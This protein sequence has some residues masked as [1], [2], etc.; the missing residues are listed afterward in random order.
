MITSSTLGRAAAPLSS[1]LQP[2]AESA[3][4]PA[5]PAAPAWRKRRRLRRASLMIAGDASGGSATLPGAL[6]VSV[7]RLVPLVLVALLALPAAAAAQLPPPA[8]LLPPGFVSEPE[9]VPVRS[10]RPLSG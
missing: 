10:C 3:A 1:M 4:A 2:A 8:P 9:R 6:P 5:A 7:P